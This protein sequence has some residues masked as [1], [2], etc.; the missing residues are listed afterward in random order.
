MLKVNSK[1]TRK[2]SLKSSDVFGFKF[3]HISKLFLV[4]LLLMLSIYLSANIQIYS[5][6]GENEEQ[7]SFEFRPVVLYSGERCA[8]KV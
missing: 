6:H 8:K 7:K 1:D 3:E 4:F 5:E 2:T